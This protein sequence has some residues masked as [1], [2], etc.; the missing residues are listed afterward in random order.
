VEP[1]PA[2]LDPE[3]ELA[4]ARGADDVAGLDLVIAAEDIERS[5]DIE[6]STG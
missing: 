5:L 6:R 1:A 4:R 2:S 3:H